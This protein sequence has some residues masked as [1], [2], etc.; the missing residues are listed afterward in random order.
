MNSQFCLPGVWSRD[1]RW[2]W[3]RGLGQ[4]AG[5]SVVARRLFLGSG[6]P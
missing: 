6:D 2:D 5:R 4:A 1:D 3:R